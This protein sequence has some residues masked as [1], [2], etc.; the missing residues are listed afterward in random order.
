MFTTH[1]AAA[2]RCKGLGKARGHEITAKIM[3]DSKIT[4]TF[5]EADGTWKALG[6]YGPW[7][8]SAI[9]IHTRDI[10]EPFHN[11]WKDISASHKKDIQYKIVC[12]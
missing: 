9:D 10:C 3:K 1:D 4:I 5:E 8:D 7:F 6:D 12:W 2:R 11:A